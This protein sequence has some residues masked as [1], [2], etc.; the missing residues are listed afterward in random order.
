[1]NSVYIHI[2]FCSDI[3]SYCDF[4][5][6]YYK[7]EWVTIYLDSLEQEIKSY[8]PKEKIKT[9]YFGGGTPSCLSI[10]ELERLF[11]ITNSLIRDK[12]CEVT[13]ECNI[14]SINEDKIKLL[15]NNGVNRLSFGI[16]TF[17]ETYLKYLNRKHSKTDSLNII[18]IAKKYIPNINIDLMYAFNNQTIESLRED[19]KEFIKL[20]VPHISTYSLIIEPHTVLGNNNTK[21]INEELD[22]DM[23]KEIKINLEKSG[24]EHYEISNFSKPG[25]Q[26]KH[27]LTYWNNDSYYGFG[28][29]AS[30]YVGN[31]RYTNTRSFKNYNN[32]N[33]VLEK[34]ELTIKTK[35]EYEMILGLRKIEGVSLENFKRKYN[36]NINEVFE[37]EKLIKKGYLE[38]ISGYI[39][40]PGQ[41]LYISNEILLKFVGE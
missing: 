16:Q 38:N 25:Y 36:K 31:I 22:Y 10:D 35:M 23:Y 20:D 26:S 12:E 1:M 19:I 9:L 3:C 21:Q 8:S 14:D 17:N 13:F 7:K 27:N 28:L 4:C 32:Y 6:M 18:K 41:Y 39:R 40:I 33:Y 5:K 37:I 30:G 2:P 15:K 24:Y 29:G 34:E 11:K